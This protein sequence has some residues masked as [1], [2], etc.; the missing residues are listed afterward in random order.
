MSLSTTRR[1]D[2]RAATLSGP[3][4]SRA[5]CTDAFAVA[6]HELRAGDVSPTGESQLIL[7]AVDGSLMR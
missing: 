2:G 4:P 7:A 1:A 3:P 6:D 5:P